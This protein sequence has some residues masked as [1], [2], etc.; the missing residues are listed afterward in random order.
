MNYIKFRKQ[1][2]EQWASSQVASVGTFT[3]S[4]NQYRIIKAQA[5]DEI[6]PLKTYENNT[7][8]F[9]DMLLSE[10]ASN[11][12]LFSTEGL[13]NKNDIYLISQS[14]FHLPKN[15]IRIVSNII[16]LNKL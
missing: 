10:Q 1:E 9:D 4:L 14:C 5:A 6:Q 2:R 15:T 11:F 7:S 13:Q 12:N 16:F 3:K 8:V